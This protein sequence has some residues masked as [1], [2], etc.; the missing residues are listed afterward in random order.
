MWW[1][2]ATANGLRRCCKASQHHRQTPGGYDKASRRPLTQHSRAPSAVT[3][4]ESVSPTDRLRHL[5]VEPGTRTGCMSSRS[6]FQQ[7]MPPSP[8]WRPHAVSSEMLTAS[9]LPPP[10]TA[11]GVALKDRS[12]Q[13]SAASVCMPQDQL[14]PSARRAH[15]APAGAYVYSSVLLSEVQK[16]ALPWVLMP[17]A[18]VNFPPNVPRDCQLAAVQGE[19]RVRAGRAWFACAAANKGPAGCAGSDCNQMTHW[20]WRGSGP[21]AGPSAG[22]CYCWRRRTSPGC[23]P[24]RTSWE[25]WGRGGC[26]CEE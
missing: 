14:S 22:W 3:P 24:G 7:Y 6:S 21:R 16:P 4:Q 15:C 19:G 11:T 25:A 20:R 1:R 18:L 2:S 17:H 12:Q 10:G 9:Q 23:P 13:S 26:L 5:R 8:C